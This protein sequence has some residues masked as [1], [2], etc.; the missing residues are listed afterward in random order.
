METL[1]DLFE[2]I[3]QKEKS[4]GFKHRISETFPNSNG[5]KNELSYGQKGFLFL[6][7]F[8]KEVSPDNIFVA[9]KIN[10][11][12]DQV[13]LEKSLKK[14]I[15]KHEV[16]RTRYKKNSYLY[17][18]EKFESKGESLD[19]C[20]VKDLTDGELKEVI[21]NEIYKP[22]DIEKSLFSFKLYRRKEDDS[23]LL[24]KFHHSIADYWSLRIIAEDLL[25]FYDSFA[26]GQ[27]PETSES[28]NKYSDFVRW[29]KSFAESR[30]GSESLNFWK[31][32]LGNKLPFLSL[33]I[34]KSFV[35]ENAFRGDNCNFNFRCRTDFANQRIQFKFKSFALYDSVSFV[36]R[37]TFQIHRTGRTDNRFAVFGKNFRQ[38]VG[39]CRVFCQFD[40]CSSEDK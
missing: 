6:H 10:H 26:N 9:A 19:I 40:A 22:F 34:G 39:N 8:Y 24:L 30:K 12:I 36:F 7:Q 25:K 17:D 18:V 27:T 28:V 3:R 20:V 29:Q 4:N 38:M 31:K 11:K 1:D 33:P 15:E 37:F 13:Y 23:V 16:L 21:S 2:E 32:R 5:E 14:I 35:K